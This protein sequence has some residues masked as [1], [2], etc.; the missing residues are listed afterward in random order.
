M[1]SERISKVKLILFLYFFYSVSYIFIPANIPTTYICLFIL[2]LYF[3]F[4]TAK[5]K[6][7]KITNGAAFIFS[8]LFLFVS[9]ISYLINKNDADLFMV[10]TASMYLIMTIII[11][12]L[13]VGLFKK[14]F[15]LLFKT[16]GYIAVINGFMILAMFLVKPFQSAYLMLI[17]D[18][19]FNLIGGTG[20]LSGFMSLRMIGI[21]GFS[22]YATGFLQCL[23]GMCYCYYMFL[24]DTKIILKLRDYIVLGIIILSA[25]I[26]ARSSLVGITFILAILFINMNFFKFW[27][28]ILFV[29]LMVIS[30]LILVIF[31]TPPSMKE[32]FVTWVTEFFVSGAET[33]SLQTNINMYVYTLSDFNLIGD[34]RWYGDINSSN[35]YMG[36]DVGWYRLAFSVGFIGAT[37]WLLTLVSFFRLKNILSLSLKFE[38]IFSKFLFLYIIIVMFKGAILFD[39]FQSV[40]ILLIVDCANK[41]RT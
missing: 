10:R 1:I 13:V 14:D 36:T 27:K 8:F 37:V 33:G 7:I 11:H 28:S 21:N 9:V 23:C 25:L 26:S 5:I 4:Y 31:L 2:L 19:A 32:F 34:S 17:S 20:A 24:R 39:S 40:L 16:I 15:I 12:S 41:Y 35:Y 6:S 29:A 3:V 30:M 22:A 38:T 18:K